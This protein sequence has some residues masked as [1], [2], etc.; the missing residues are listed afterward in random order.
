MSEEIYDSLQYN[1]NM[2]YSS[3]FVSYK[4]REP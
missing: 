1:I 3:S 4:E 2:Q